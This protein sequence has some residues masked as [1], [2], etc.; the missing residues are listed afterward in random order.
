MLK[1]YVKI[2][3]T[4]MLDFHVQQHKKG[5]TQNKMYPSLSVTP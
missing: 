3:Y 4:M 1:K 5:I 2:K